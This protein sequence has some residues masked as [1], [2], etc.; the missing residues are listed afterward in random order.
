MKKIMIAATAICVAAFVHA[1]TASWTATNIAYAPSS[2]ATYSAFLIDNDIGGYADYEAAMTAILNDGSSAAGV[3]AVK[4]G[5][6]DSGTKL[7]LSATG[8]AIVDRTP[9]SYTAGESIVAMMII[10]DAA[11]DDLDNA[12]N[13]MGATKAAAKF[14]NSLALNAGFGTQASNSWQAVPEP[15]SGLLLLLGVAGLALRRRRA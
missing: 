12:K 2:A 6:T 5:L 11:S 15:T 10:F 7:G 8:T 3:L 1:A 13:Y 9:S 4:D 14:N